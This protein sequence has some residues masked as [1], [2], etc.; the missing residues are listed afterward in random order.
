MNKILSQNLD[1]CNVVT[2][3]FQ[4]SKRMS[5][6]AKSAFLKES[7]IDILQS[8]FMEFIIG[9]LNLIVQYMQLIKFMIG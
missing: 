3:N 9:N 2:R 8:H 6:M 5:C 1:F 7:L 4:R